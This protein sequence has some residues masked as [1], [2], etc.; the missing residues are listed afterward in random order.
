MKT[1]WKEKLIRFMTGRYGGADLLNRTLMIG[2]LLLVLIA[3]FVPGVAS[4][5]LQL[6]GI[7]L[8]GWSYFRIFS[9]NIA[10][11]YQE[12]QRFLTFVNKTFKQ[13]MARLRGS[14]EFRY[15]ACPK[16]RTKV[17]VPRGKGKVRIR[18]PKCSEV[19]ER[20]A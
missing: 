20:K 7:A 9:R 19:F 4:L 15:F 8:L 14:R 17:R 1:N 13:P 16:C 10:R 18:C 12:N 2:G 11:R 5:I 6:A 3:A